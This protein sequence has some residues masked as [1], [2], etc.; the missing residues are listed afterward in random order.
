MKKL[1]P[2]EHSNPGRRVKRDRR[3]KNL[4]HYGTTLI[5]VG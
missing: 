4:G 3:M 2:F 5:L 1:C